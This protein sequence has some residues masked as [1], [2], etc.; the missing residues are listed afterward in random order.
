MLA[1]KLKPSEQGSIGSGATPSTDPIDSD[2]S[3]QTKTFAA[4]LRRR[5]LHFTPSWFSVNMGTG[6]TSILL[7]NLPYNNVYLQRIA[8]CI[9]VL[10]IGAGFPLFPLEVFFTSPAVFRAALFVIFLG[11]SITRY[12]LYPQVWNLMIR[13][14][15][16]SLFIGTFP[17]GFATLISE[18]W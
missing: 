1:P 6:I 10:N 5:V 13:N 4:G 16:Q 7:H 3:V 14:P 9:F 11:I 18:S 17:M 15:A 12:I 8:V 2:V